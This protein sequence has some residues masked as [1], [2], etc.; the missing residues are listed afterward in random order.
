MNILFICSGKNK[1]LPSPILVNQAKSLEV[2]GHY[3][4]YYIISKKGLLGYLQHLFLLR[5]YLSKN[6]FEIYHAHY[7]YS[8]I[9]AALAGAKPLVVS[10]MGSDVKGKSVH[11]II[12]KVF[13]KFVWQKTIVKSEEMKRN[14]G[15][16][17]LEVI[18]NG[19]DLKK[20]VPIQKNYA[21]TKTLWDSKKKHV[22]FAASKF[23]PEKNYRLA[24]E[25]FEYL[26]KKGNHEIELH[27]IEDVDNEFMPFI[28][29][30]ADVILLTSFHE[31]S[32]NVVKE[33]MAC[34]KPVISTNVGDVKE[35]FKGCINC[36]VVNY[37]KIEIS[38]EIE[39]VIYGNNICNSK[40]LI[41]RLDSNIIANRIIL[42][43]KTVKEKCVE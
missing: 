2:I 4:S 35:L 22:L 1:N 28:Y 31:G 8:G 38:N 41:S 10:L 20:F 40:E 32:P 11:N 34:N 13:A 24:F 19:V 37:D 25:A 36:H 33:A 12:V 6:K 9:V 21:L 16:S 30:S 15:I 5:R 18:P 3:V 26:K 43:Y 17:N 27:T 23:R 29:N 7:S 39:R 14:L 42:I